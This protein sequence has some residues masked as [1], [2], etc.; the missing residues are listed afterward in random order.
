MYLVAPPVPAPKKDQPRFSRRTTGCLTDFKNLQMR[1]TISELFDAICK[2]LVGLH[3]AK[4]VGVILIQK[5]GRPEVLQHVRLA[6]ED[7]WHDFSDKQHDSHV[8]IALDTL[9][10]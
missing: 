3:N 2:P 5:T 10:D 6:A 4:A 8:W 7:G 9:K 1:V